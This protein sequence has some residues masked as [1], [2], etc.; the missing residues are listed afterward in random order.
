MWFLLVY[1]LKATTTMRQSCLLC[2]NCYL[3]A[4]IWLSAPIVSAKPTYI[5]YM[6]PYI[7]ICV[8]LF[9]YVH[10]FVCINVWMLSECMCIC[11]NIGHTN[12]YEI[13]YCPA[14]RH[15]I[16]FKINLSQF[17][18]CSVTNEPKRTQLCRGKWKTPHNFNTITTQYTDMAITTTTKQCNKVFTWIHNNN[19]I[20]NAVVPS[21][22]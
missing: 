21:N 13:Y 2:C 6:Y 1:L 8:Y 15:I 10:V 9:V 22:K 3:L 12:V 19:N 5:T 7:Y 16:H 4:V 20:N 11:T 18:C 14:V 17:V